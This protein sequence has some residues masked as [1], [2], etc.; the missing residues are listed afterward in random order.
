MS[1]IET[2]RVAFEKWAADQGYSLAAIEVGYRKIQYAS[3]LTRVALDA[4]QAGRASMTASTAEP[5]G[6]EQ[7]D[8]S[9]QTV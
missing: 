1:D 5:E 4:F 2:Q 8:G 9:D 3:H 6:W 7:G